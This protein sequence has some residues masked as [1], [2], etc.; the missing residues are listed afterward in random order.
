MK[1]ISIWAPAV[2]AGSAV[3]MSDQLSKWWALSA[4]DEH[5]IIDLFWTLRLRLVF[6]TGAAFSQGE[7]LGPIFAVLVLV[8]LIV[9]ARHGA[10]LNDPRARLAIGII[11]GGALGNLADRL[12]R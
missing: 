12:F 9:V 10:K 3:L 11:T 2:A 4:L 1:K 7:G 8:V 5:Q 6:N